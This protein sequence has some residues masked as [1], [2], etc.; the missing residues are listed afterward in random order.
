MIEIYT[1][2]TIWID[3]EKMCE[4][5]TKA[6]IDKAKALEFF[7]NN[8]ED[9]KQFRSEVLDDD[10]EDDYDIDKWMLE[11]LSV[12]KNYDDLKLKHYVYN[13]GANEKIFEF[14]THKMGD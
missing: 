14:K 11:N 9:W 7:N 5:E 3:N 2:S 8:F 12:Y 10:G 1:V 13:D 6:F 4:H